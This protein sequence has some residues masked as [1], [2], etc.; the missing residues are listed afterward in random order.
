MALELSKEKLTEIFI[1]FNYLSLKYNIDFIVFVHIHGRGIVMHSNNTCSILRALIIQE[2]NKIYE[3]YATLPKSHKCPRNTHDGI[4]IRQEISLIIKGYTKCS[5]WMVVGYKD[6]SVRFFNI[7]GRFGL[8][9]F[10]IEVI[11]KDLIINC[12]NTVPSAKG[13]TFL[14][15]I[16]ALEKLS[17]KQ[18]I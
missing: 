12:Y 17:K 9:M 6:D 18:L 7:F 15:D 5:G 10:G 13:R 4:Q 16:S 1:A 3:K 11:R 2:F 8:K 14:E